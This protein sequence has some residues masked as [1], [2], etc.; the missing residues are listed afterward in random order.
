MKMFPKVHGAEATS[1]PS[2]YSLASEPLITAAKWWA[3]SG[4]TAEALL[5]RMTVSLRLKLVTEKRKDPSSRRMTSN[6]RK[7]GVLVDSPTK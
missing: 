6:S 3:V 2:R 1:T 5:A 7:R 4:D